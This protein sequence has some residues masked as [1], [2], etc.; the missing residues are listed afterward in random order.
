MSLTEFSAHSNL[1]ERESRMVRAIETGDQTTLD[2]ELIQLDKIQ[3]ECLLY[4]DI[5]AIVE[6]RNAVLLKVNAMGNHNWKM[7][8]QVINDKG[9]SIAEA[10][11]VTRSKRH[12]QNAD[13]FHQCVFRNL[14]KFRPWEMHSTRNALGLDEII[15]TWVDAGLQHFA[16]PLLTEL[17]ATSRHSQD[18]QAIILDEIKIA[19][20]LFDAS[21]PEKSPV[22]A[23]AKEHQQSIIDLNGN[24][25]PFVRSMPYDVIISIANSGLIDIARLA[26]ENTQKLPN[27]GDLYRLRAEAGIVLD[28]QKIL[29]MWSSAAETDRLMPGKLIALT[30]YTMAYDDAPIPEHI[31][32]A[33][34]TAIPRRIDCSLSVLT[35]C[36]INHD[37][38]RAAFLL[39]YWWNTQSSPFPALKAQAWPESFKMACEGYRTHK[40]ERDLG[41]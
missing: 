22:I 31:N 24:A 25:M 23:W 6:H 27:Q 20:E 41:L 32:V 10:A 21:A 13:D 15:R 5:T 2:N 37:P 19:S 11:E 9:L 7:Q 8:I 1:L 38:L 40:L 14:M 39:D 33:E 12:L 29:A 26:L 17:L 16:H 3:I 35:D 4:G 18:L 28:D 34:V 36:G 30:I